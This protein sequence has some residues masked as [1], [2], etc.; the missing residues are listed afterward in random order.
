MGRVE[1]SIEKGHSAKK[2]PHLATSSNSRSSCLTLSQIGLSVTMSLLQPIFHFNYWEVR[3]NTTFI[4]EEDN[5]L[6]GLYSLTY[7]SFFVRVGLSL[8]NE[9]Q[10]FLTPL[11]I[12][13]SWRTWRERVSHWKEGKITDRIVDW[14]IDRSKTDLSDYT[15]V[16]LWIIQ[17]EIT[18]LRI[19]DSYIFIDYELSRVC[20][21]DVFTHRK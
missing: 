18:K 1:K 14:F 2:Y 8:P 12:C 21:S 16:T 3:E 13:W 15:A 10:A 5:G 20:L 19:L 17:K 7:F 4:P 11:S 9:R 6:Y